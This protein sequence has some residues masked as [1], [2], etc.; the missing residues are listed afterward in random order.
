KDDPFILAQL[1]EFDGSDSS[2]IYVSLN[3]T[4]FD[5]SAKADVYG[6]GKSYN[7]FP[8]KDG[9]KGFESRV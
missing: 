7:I 5:L 2:P 6:S 3:G 8:G 9:S 1:K 4:V